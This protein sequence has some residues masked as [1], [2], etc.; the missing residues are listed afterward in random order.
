MS[1]TPKQ[2]INS[3]CRSKEFCKWFREPQT[4][5]ER[6]I[7]QP[8]NGKGDCTGFVKKEGNDGTRN[9]SNTEA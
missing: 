1:K 9:I 4:D 8:R 2:C 5:W 6:S 3:A 7:K